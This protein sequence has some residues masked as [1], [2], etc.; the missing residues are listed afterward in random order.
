MTCAAPEDRRLGIIMRMTSRNM[1]VDWMRTISSKWAISVAMVLLPGADCAANQQ[2][3]SDG[4]CAG[5][6][7]TPGI[8]LQPYLKFPALG[9]DK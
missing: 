1:S 5:I 8:D 2:Q 3:Q 4:R 9:K 6:P 7:T